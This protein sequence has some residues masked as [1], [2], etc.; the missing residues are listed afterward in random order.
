MGEIKSFSAR[1]SI[2]AYLT[3]FL[4]QLQFKLK[5]FQDTAKQR[6]MTPQELLTTLRGGS[7]YYKAQVV[8][9]E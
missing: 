2:T 4:D 8:I 9:C 5:Q 6:T 1:L 7:N 3:F